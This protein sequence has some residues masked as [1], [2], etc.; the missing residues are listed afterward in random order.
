MENVHKK[1]ALHPIL[2]FLVHLLTVR[3][4]FYVQQNMTRKHTRG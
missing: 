2:Q 3:A 4:G 1:N